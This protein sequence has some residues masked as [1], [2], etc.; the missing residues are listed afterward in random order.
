MQPT[1]TLLF[2]GLLVI[3]VLE[4]G[5]KT[6]YDQIAFVKFAPKWVKAGRLPR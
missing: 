5:T 1:L 6:N 4:C 2:T 3:A